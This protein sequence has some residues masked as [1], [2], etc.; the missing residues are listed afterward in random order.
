[1]S[2]PFKVSFFNFFRKVFQFP[3]LER[4]LANLTREKPPHHFFCKFVPNPYQYNKPSFRDIT[5]Q[6]IRMRVDVSDYIGH[7]YFF[8]FKDH[9]QEKLFAICKE[10]FNILDIGANI[11]FTVLKF[12]QQAKLGKIVGFEPDPFNYSCCIHN[13][14]Q[15]KFENAAVLNIGLGSE[16]TILDLEFRTPGN[17]SGNRIRPFGSNPAVKVQ[18]KNLD[19]FFPQLS[20]DHLDLVKIDVEGYEMQVLRGSE[21]TLRKFRPVL[22]IEIDNDN[23]MDHGDSAESVIHFIKRRGYQSIIHA[24]SLQPLTNGFD[25]SHCHFDIIAR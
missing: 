16:D 12:A 1:M 19:I 6:G 17:R 4:W 25:F 18:V 8:G 11:G 3:P 20:M 14:Q 22:F 24:E 15:N 10:N 21:G 9:A 7:Y 5:V 23:L 2:L 13:L